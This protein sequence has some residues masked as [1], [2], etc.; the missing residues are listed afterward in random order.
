MVLGGF[1]MGSLEKFIESP[2]TALLIAIVVGA[3]ALSGKFSAT[4]TQMLLVV[5]WA[6]TIVGMRGHPLVM[7]V[8]V[9]AIAG[10]S[11]LLL[12]YLF[13]PDAVPSNF[14]ELTPPE[15]IF[16]SQTKVAARVLEIGD[17]GAIIPTGTIDFGGSTLLLETIHGKLNVSTQIRDEKGDLI[18]NLERNEWKT[19]TQLKSWDRNYTANALEVLDAAGHV[20]LQVVLR[21]DKVQL[22]GEWRGPNGHSIRMVKSKENGHG[23]MIGYNG[24]PAPNT[25]VIEPIFVYP[26]ESH[27]GELKAAK[28]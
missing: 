1:I 22:Q 6:V 5:A 11:L 2:Y 13:R 7:Q 9:G 4:A 14:G 27:L 21:A 8:G 24:S 19:S 10:G 20:V 15:P 16:S 28:H 12:G 23:L 3:L 18:A 17:S 25:P 26:S